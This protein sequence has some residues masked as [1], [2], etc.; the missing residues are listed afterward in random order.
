MSHRKRIHKYKNTGIQ[1]GRRP[2]KDTKNLSKKIADNVQVSRS[3][4]AGPIC[5]ARPG[6]AP[7]FFLPVRDPEKTR[8]TEPCF[9]AKRLTDCY[10][11]CALE[12][13]YYL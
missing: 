13:T 4:A 9:R 11:K 12:S 8:E 3:W 6:R 1:P 7:I 2:G 5:L 10:A